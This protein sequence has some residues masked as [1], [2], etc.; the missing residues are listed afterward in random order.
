MARFWIQ[1]L[2]PPR[3][4][5]SPEG[6]SVNLGDRCEWSGVKAGFHLAEYGKERALLVGVVSTR[7]TGRLARRESG[8]VSQAMRSGLAGPGPHLFSGFP[9][10]L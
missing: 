6:L 10:S 9:S 4:S 1:A 7:A 8:D 3:K 5:S 2:R